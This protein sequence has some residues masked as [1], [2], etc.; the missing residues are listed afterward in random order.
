MLEFKE[1]LYDTW[2]SP[3]M[4]VNLTKLNNIDGGRWL[5]SFTN[6]V[7]LDLVGVSQPFVVR[8]PIP[9]VI[10]YDEEFDSGKILDWSFDVRGAFGT[11]LNST[12]YI[13]CLITGLAKRCRL[14]RSCSGQLGTEN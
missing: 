11:S 5:I 8:N 1:K 3:L 14:R 10:K 13:T 6:F 12:W 2:E 9:A 7:D 4:A